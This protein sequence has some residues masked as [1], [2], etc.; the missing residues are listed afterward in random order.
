MLAALRDKNRVLASEM[1][2][3]TRRLWAATEAAALGYG[4]ISAVAEATGMAMSTICIGM[5]ELKEG[6]REE[7][8]ESRSTDRRVRRSGAGRKPLNETDPRLLKALEALVE[9][10]T[11]GDPMSPLRWT[12]KSTRN[13]AEELQ[14]QGHSVSHETVA[15]MLHELDY[16]LQGNRKTREG[17]AHP[18]RNAQFEHLNAKVREFQRHGQ[19]VISV[20]GKKKE[21]VGDFKNGGREWRPQ[22]D[23]IKVRTHDFQDKILG[24]VSPYGVYDVT[25]NNGWMSVGIDHDTAEFA[26]ETIRQWWRQMGRR[27]YPEARELLIA[28]D[29][30][31]SNS[32]RT[33]LWKVA[34][35]KLADETGLKLSI[36]H[37]PPG[38][39]KWNKIEHRMFCHVTR[40]WRGRPLESRE[41]IVNLISNTT[42]T[43]GL[44]IQAALDLGSYPKGIEVSDEA[45]AQV[46][47]KRDLFH[48]DWNYTII[49]QS[50]KTLE[51]NV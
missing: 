25:H 42:T 34:L 13:L 33:R 14:R 10:T 43:K 5:R 6:V 23:P 19:P 22:G 32:S 16:S 20:D 41:I 26:V 45:L 15:Q 9:P 11:R 51:Q 1:D 31:G 44:R 48:G 36:C 50:P 17:S 37:Y 2:E 46:C 40:N 35:Q 27:A 47:L 8:S 30:G 28:A 12:C 4:G 49:P 18:D 39:S 29:S 7:G 38:T 21:L 3:R 24:K